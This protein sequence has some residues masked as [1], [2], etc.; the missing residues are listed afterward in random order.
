MRQ[1]ATMSGIRCMLLRGGT[2]KGAYFLLDDLPTDPAERD[3]LLLRI[4]GSPDARQIDGI[5]G[6]H[7]LTS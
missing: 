6:A 3:E 1:T 5:G 2:S 4:V 7:P